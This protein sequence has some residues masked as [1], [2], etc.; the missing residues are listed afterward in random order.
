MNARKELSEGLDPFLRRPWL[1]GSR[2]CGKLSANWQ[3]RIQSTRV[4][5]PRS[6]QKRRSGNQNAHWGHARR[7][8]RSRI[9]PPSVQSGSSA[10]RALGMRREKVIRNDSDIGHVGTR[11]AYRDDEGMGGSRGSAGLPWPPATVSG[12]RLQDENDPWDVLPGSADA[13]WPVT[14]LRSPAPQAVALTT[15]STL[16]LPAARIV[17]RHPIKCDLCSRPVPSG[18][19][20]VWKEYGQ[21]TWR[22]RHQ[23]CR[24]TKG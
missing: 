5:N 22:G 18:E 15:P 19:G 3:P 20:W 4:E 16:P 12:L 13:E 14:A 9:A 8:T 11:V 24:G 17:N 23:S 10:E 6:G 7:L 1:G 21:P 2:G